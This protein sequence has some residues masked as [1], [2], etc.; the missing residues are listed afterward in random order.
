MK[1]QLTKLI[2]LI[3]LIQKKIEIY[4]DADNDNENWTD[5]KSKKQIKADKFKL[6]AVI[7][8][9]NEHQEKETR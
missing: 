4:T 1:I 3:K 8:L 5:V 6:P 7:I 2:I 9:D